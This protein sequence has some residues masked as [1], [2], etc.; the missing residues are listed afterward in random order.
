M[1][2][3]KKSDYIFIYIINIEKMSWEGNVFYDVIENTDY[4]NS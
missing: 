3:D 4:S 1:S 2:Y